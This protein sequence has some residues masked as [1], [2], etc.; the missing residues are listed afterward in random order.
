MNFDKFFQYKIKIDKVMKDLAEGLKNFCEDEDIV[1]NM[2][3]MEFKNINQINSNII[4]NGKD[5]EEKK[6]IQFK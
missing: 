5:T 2:D 3:Y 6:T 1:L 4:K